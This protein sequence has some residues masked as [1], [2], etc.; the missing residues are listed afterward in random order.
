MDHRHA[1]VV[2]DRPAS[3]ASHAA[4]GHFFVIQEEIFV[5]PTHVVEHFPIQE[6]TGSGDPIDGTRAE[7]PFGLVLSP[8]SWYQLLPRGPEEV[9]ED[10]HG[11]L[12]GTVRVAESEPHDAGR[13]T[14]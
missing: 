5:H 1:R 10:P 9:G 13:A 11:R 14:P 4:K 3:I 6:H 7:P 12:A 8:G 2:L